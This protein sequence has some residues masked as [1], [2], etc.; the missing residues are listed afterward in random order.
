MLQYAVE[1][2][3]S[4]C[5][6]VICRRRAGC[7]VNVTPHLLQ[8]HPGECKLHSGILVC[9]SINLYLPITNAAITLYRNKYFETNFNSFRSTSRLSNSK[10]NDF[11]ELVFY[12]RNE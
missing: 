8:N 12:T 3:D 11:N 9:A 6:D 1:L 7:V 2:C 10:I 4:S 5:L